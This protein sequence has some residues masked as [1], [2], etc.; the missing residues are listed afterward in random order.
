MN[1]PAGRGPHS[2][3]V[4]T[5]IDSSVVTV[6]GDLDLDH[7]D[8]LNSVL[9]VACSDPGA[10]ERVVVDL[11]RLAFCDSAGLNALLRARL[12]CES[13]GRTLILAD[14]GP[15]FLRLLSITGADLLFNISAPDTGETGYGP[16]RAAP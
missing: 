8:A 12:L 2:V 11:T 7:V 15:Q 3:T 4:V 1:L 9:L 10:P 6:T 14:P 16:T 13:N 5:R